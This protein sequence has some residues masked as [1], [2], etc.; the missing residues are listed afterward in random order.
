MNDKCM[1]DVISED[2]VKEFESYTS[3][4]KR[5]LGKVVP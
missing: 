5:V 1:I 4:W 2:L 3:F